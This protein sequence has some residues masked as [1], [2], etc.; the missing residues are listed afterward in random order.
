VS[1]TALRRPA[2]LFVAP[3]AAASFAPGGCQHVAIVIGKINGGWMMDFEFES[4]V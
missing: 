1:L 4:L 2:L 3:V